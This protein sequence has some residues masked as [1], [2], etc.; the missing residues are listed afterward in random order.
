MAN[1][2]RGGPG[3]G[4]GDRELQVTKPKH[5]RGFFG[6]SGGADLALPDWVRGA[7]H[8]DPSAPF[9]VSQVPELTAFLAATDFLSLRAVGGFGEAGVA[10]WQTHGT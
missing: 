6:Q 8:E 7:V 1:T 10:K 9:R 2:R 3:S 4:K 5:D